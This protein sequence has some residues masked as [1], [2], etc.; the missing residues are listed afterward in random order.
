MSNLFGKSYVQDA[1]NEEKS[2]HFKSK[3]MWDG[4]EEENIYLNQPGHSVSLLTKAYQQLKFC[5]HY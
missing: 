1:L 3:K 4:G 5:E 2:V